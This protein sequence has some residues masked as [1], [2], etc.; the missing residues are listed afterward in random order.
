M[1]APTRKVAIGAT[2]FVALTVLIG[3]QYLP[4]HLRLRVGEESRRDIVA[5]RV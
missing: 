2:R 3:G 1:H 4:A 5:P